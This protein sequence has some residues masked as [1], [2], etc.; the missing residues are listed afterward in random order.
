MDASAAPAPGAGV[1][2]ASNL[3]PP[4]RD[5]LDDVALTGNEGADVDMTRLIAVDEEEL[6]D[7]EEE[8]GVSPSQ[9]SIETMKL[10]LSGGV[11]GAVSKTTTAPLA[12][13]TILYQVRC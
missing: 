2:D 7:E 9:E 12:R 3:H 11:A 1:L 8:L 13:L 10:L 6:L 5:D 4:W